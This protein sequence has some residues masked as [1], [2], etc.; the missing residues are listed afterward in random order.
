MI[1]KLKKEV[2][3]KALD[4]A[5]HGLHQRLGCDPIKHR[6]IGIKQDLL[7]AQEQNA[8]LDC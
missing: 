2:R 5:F 7:T 8:L 4:V 3:W 1:G 6:E